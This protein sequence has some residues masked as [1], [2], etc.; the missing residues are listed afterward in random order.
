[1]GAV[2]NSGALSP[3]IENGTSSTTSHQ[4][5]SETAVTP[6]AVKTRTGSDY[7]EKRMSKE[8]SKRNSSQAATPMKGRSRA[9]TRRLRQRA[10][11]RCGTRDYIAPEV[12]R[13][14]GYG[15]QVDMWSLGVVTFVIMSGLM[16]TY[17]EGL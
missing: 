2:Q 11:T 12:L 16:P 1:M 6:R 8:L 14:G 17:R 10:H 15:T 13:G 5:L 3:L 9:S 4:E 7:I